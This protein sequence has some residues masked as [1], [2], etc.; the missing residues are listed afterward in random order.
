MAVT[1]EGSGL[2]P[3]KA[4]PTG[5]TTQLANDAMLI[6]PVI[7]VNVMRVVSTISVIV[8]NHFFFFFFWHF[9]DELQF[10]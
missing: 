4:I 2:V 6:T 9:V 10:H 7:T 8:L 1:R 5:T 3:L